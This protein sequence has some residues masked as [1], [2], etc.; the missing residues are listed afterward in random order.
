MSK[1]GAEPKGMQK[2][3]RRNENQDTITEAQLRETEYVIDEEKGMK[4]EITP[5]MT[6]TLRKIATAVILIVKA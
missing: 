1:R 5:Q 6:G 4:H 3:A 2:R